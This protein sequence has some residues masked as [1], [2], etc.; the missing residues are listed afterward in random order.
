V[1]IVSILDTVEAP[2]GI[3]RDFQLP[4]PPYYKVLVSYDGAQSLMKQIWH[5]RVPWFLFCEDSQLP[6]K[7]VVD[8]DPMGIVPPRPV[9]P[10][11]ID[12]AYLSRA[13]PYARAWLLDF[14]HGPE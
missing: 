10:T 4:S 5:D 11:V 14:G 3:G 13:E 1:D 7:E 8:V 12:R 6:A 2:G 9:W